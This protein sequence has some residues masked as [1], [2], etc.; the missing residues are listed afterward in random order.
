MDAENQTS[1]K[2]VVGVTS[3][4]HGFLPPALIQALSGVDLILHAGDLDT[5][6][7]LQRLEEIAPVKAITGNTDHHPAFNKTPSTQLIEV[8]GVSIYMIHDLLR[9]N[10][11]L[12]AAGVQVLIHG[13]L[14]VPEIRQRQDV[15]YINP[16]SPSSPRG[17]SSPGYVKLTIQN[18]TPQAEWFALR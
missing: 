15:L 17:G 18:Q 1:E 3:D 10:I 12:P 9:L 5:P 16:G 14:H 6:D 13:H 4:T 11:D 2:I 7:I 8:G